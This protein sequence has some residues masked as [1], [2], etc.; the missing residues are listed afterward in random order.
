MLLWNLTM[1]FI[2]DLIRDKKIWLIEIYKALEDM[3]EYITA[4]H[5]NYLKPPSKPT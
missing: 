5:P 2:N 1:E 4:K 3:V